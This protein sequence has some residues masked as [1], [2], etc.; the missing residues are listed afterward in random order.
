MAVLAIVL[1]TM[2]FTTLFTLTQSMGRNMTEMYLRQSGTK[3]HASTKKITDEQIAQL[4]AHPDIVCF[5]KSIVLGTAKN[6]CLAGRQVELRYAS[7]QYAQDA[8]AY[9][10]TGKMPEH[11]DEIALDTQVL[12]RLDISPSLGETVLL[13]WG[14]WF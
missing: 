9:P 2:M 3:A 14:K 13:E 5:G 7:D 6:Q 4:S 1:T 12:A 11:K 10:T 8:F